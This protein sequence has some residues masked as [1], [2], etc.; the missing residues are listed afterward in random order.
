VA[1]EDVLA[2]R[3][4]YRNKLTMHVFIVSF[5]PGNVFDKIY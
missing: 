3:H 2:E 1:A 5:I 4:F